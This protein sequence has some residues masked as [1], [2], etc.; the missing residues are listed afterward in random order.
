MHWTL[1][2]F[3]E[4]TVDELHDLLQLRI[5]IFVVE[6]NCPYPELD[7]KDKIAY[8][9]FV[10]DDQERI[11]AY[12]RIFGPGDYYEQAAIG[13]VV[14]DASKRREGL[15]YDLMKG[16]IAVVKDLYGTDKIK[17]GAQK[18]LRSFYESLG[19]VKIGKG[20]LEDGIPH[21]YMVR[22]GEGQTD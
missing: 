14:V 5:N 17:I 7:G 13:R 21:I 9:Y 4:L 11:V 3:S 19:F 8:H 18:Y 10:T 20:Y 6:Q 16:S 12:T 2:K 15:G 22:N 1:K